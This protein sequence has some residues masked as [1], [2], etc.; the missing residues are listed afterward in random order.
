[1]RTLSKENAKFGYVLPGGEHVPGVTTVLKLYGA[2]KQ[3]LMYWANIQGLKGKKLNEASEKAKDIGHLGHYLVECWYNEVS[4]RID[5]TYSKVDIFKAKEILE[6]F[7]DILGKHEGKIVGS[8]VGLA[9]PEKRFGGTIDLLVNTKN[10]EEFWDL[11][12][13]KDIY[14]EHYVQVAAYKQLLEYEGI[15]RHPRILLISK[16]GRVYAPDI[17]EKTLAA[18]T[19]IWNHILEVYHANKELEIEVG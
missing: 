19:K 5:D 3:A 10:G 12:T 15:K 4:P 14:T 13:S 17:S 7:K 8:E 16:D 18:S 9:H 2:N 11:K 1:M 6:L